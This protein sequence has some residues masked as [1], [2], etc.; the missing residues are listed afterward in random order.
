MSSPVTTPYSSFQALGL[1]HNQGRTNISRR[2]RRRIEPSCSKR[3]Q[4]TVFSSHQRPSR[5]PRTSGGFS[6]RAGRSC[7][8]DVDFL[9]DNWISSW[10]RLA[11]VPKWRLSALVLPVVR[12]NSCRGSGKGA[13]NKAWPQSVYR[14]IQTFMGGLFIITSNAFGRTWQ[15]YWK[16]SVTGRSGGTWGSLRGNNRGEI[17]SLTA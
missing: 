9:S 5:R 4:G 13:E 10:R 12:K 15:W 8:R 6:V 7:R 1:P 14:A 16:R 17:G 11:S 3:P 2:S